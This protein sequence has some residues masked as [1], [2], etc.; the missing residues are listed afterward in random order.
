MKKQICVVHVQDDYK[1]SLNVG[2]KDGVSKG[3]SFLIY[4]LS[5]HEI[6]D[7]ISKESLGFLEFVK[8][9]GTVIHV[10]ENMCTIESNKYENS[11]PR[12]TIRK[13]AGSSLIVALNGSSTTEETVIEREHVPFDN[14]EIGDFAKQI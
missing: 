2:S 8:G 7:P 9:T 14:P 1:V 6:I 12:K 11:L 3:N 10:Q 5:D 13:N 4:T